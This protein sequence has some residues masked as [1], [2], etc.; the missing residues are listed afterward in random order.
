MRCSYFSVS[1][2]SGWKTGER[3]LKID[4]EMC[5]DCPSISIYLDGCDVDIIEGFDFANLLKN[6]VSKKD[7]FF[8]FRSG[9][10]GGRK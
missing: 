1:S 6:I 2:G 4:R 10:G 3:G 9:D 5:W 8:F 7:F